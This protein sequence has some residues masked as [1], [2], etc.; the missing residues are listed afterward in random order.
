MVVYDFL[1]SVARLLKTRKDLALVEIVDELDNHNLLKPQLDEERA[2][3]NQVVFAALGWLTMLYDAVSHPKPDKLEVTKTSTSSS[4]YRNPLVTRKYCNFKQGFDYIDLPLFSLLGRYGDLIPEA[5]QYQVLEP[6]ISGA[7]AHEVIKVPTVC[8]NTLHNM[9]ELKIEW[10]TSLA[11]HLELDS[12]KKTLKLFQFPSFCRMMFVKRKNNILS[13]LLNDHAARNCEDVRTPDIA[14]EDF[15]REILLSYRLIFGQDERSWKAFSR[16][17]P[18]WEE[19]RSRVLWETSWDCDPMLHVLCGKSSSAED[20][21]RIYDDVNANEPANYYDP[22]TQFPFLGKKLV[23]LQGFIMQHQPQNVRSLLNDRRDVA[24]WYTLWNN[25]LLIFF[26]TCTI[27]LM[28][29][30]LIFQIWQVLLAKEQLKLG[31]A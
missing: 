5:R 25:Q 15:F 31:P 19:Q 23:E 8:F 10:V 29:L 16:M 1:L 11:L 14:T 9:A 30:S 6:G 21:Q 4:G 17:V 2:I 20:A 28:V 13:R 24:A 27:F 7:L 22:N 3:P 26:A 12:G 18:I